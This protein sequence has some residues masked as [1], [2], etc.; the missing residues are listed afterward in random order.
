N[1]NL[2]VKTI[3]ELVALAKDKPGTLS[4]GTFS[5]VHVQFMNR[6]NKKNGIDIVR[7]PFRSGNEVVTAVLSGTTPVAFLGF[8]NMLSQMRGGQITGIALSA[9]ARSPLFPDLPTVLEATGERYPI[10]WFGLFAPAGTPREIIDRVHADVV[11]IT[12]TPEFRQ[13]NYVERA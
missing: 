3:A 12:G 6:L 9:N 8:S 10:T 13:K 5:F 4:Y 7:V 2:K 1:S 11:E